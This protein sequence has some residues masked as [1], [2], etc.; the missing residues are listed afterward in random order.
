MWSSHSPIKRWSL[1][2]F[3]W[4]W[5]ACERG[6]GRNDI[7]WVPRLG[8][9]RFPVFHLH[10]LERFFLVVSHHVRIWLPRDHYAMKKPMLS[11]YRGREWVEEHRS[12][13]TCEWSDAGPFSLTQPR[14]VTS[15]MKGSEW[16]QPPV[17]QKDH[18]AKLNLNPW[19]TDHWQ[20]IWIYHKA[21]GFW[22]WHLTLSHSWYR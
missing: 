21:L 15:W 8:L 10:H 9:K 18:P 19:L 4:F 3:P 17:E 14:L 16:P 13:Q 12:H 5:A 6:V 1:F 20:I 11:T 22:F 2:S 7:V